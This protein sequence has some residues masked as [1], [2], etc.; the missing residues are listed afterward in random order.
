MGADNQV[1]IKKGTVAWGTV[2]QLTAGNNSGHPGSIVLSL[3]FIRLSDGSTARLA[4]SQAVTAEKTEGRAA[5]LRKKMAAVLMGP[6]GDNDNG[7][8]IPQ[9]TWVTAYIENGDRA[10]RGLAPAPNAK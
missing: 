2:T 10:A 9:G 4:G 1:A 6:K 5:S 3:D 8:V 7:P